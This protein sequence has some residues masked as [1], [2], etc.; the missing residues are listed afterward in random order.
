MDKICRLCGQNSAHL[1]SVFSLVEGGR[2]LADLIYIVCPIRIEVNDNLPKK[3]CEECMEV[4]VSSI[5]LRESSVK[6][7]LVFRLQESKEKD[8]P[9][10]DAPAFIRVKQETYFE[11]DEQFEEIDRERFEDENDSESQSDEDFEPRE[12]KLK[13]QLDDGKFPCP[14][15]CGETFAS[16]HSAKRHS[17]RFK[18]CAPSN[19]TK[20]M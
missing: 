16:R 19:F 1:E 17:I 12:K 18:H 9:I 10:E 5:K 13:G 2:L 6:S 15:K 4:V 14:A 8:N 20:G 11:D 7:D 3:I